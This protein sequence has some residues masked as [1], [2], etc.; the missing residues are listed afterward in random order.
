MKTTL[1]LIATALVIT[2]T[3]AASLKKTLKPKQD[4]NLAQA[5][6]KG[7][8][9]GLASEDVIADAEAHVAHSEVDVIAASETHVEASAATLAADMEASV[10]HAEASAVVTEV[11]VCSDLLV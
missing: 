1:I 11:I 3:E 10:T 6:S 9:G 8:Y 5:E 4:I 7:C 2:P